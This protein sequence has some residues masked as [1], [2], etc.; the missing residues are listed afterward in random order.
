M[1]QETM[2][3]QLGDEAGCVQRAVWVGQLWGGCVGC[4][5]VDFP[6]CWH[7]DGVEGGEG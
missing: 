7:G 4:W 5:L 1:A 6:S 2:A 3:G